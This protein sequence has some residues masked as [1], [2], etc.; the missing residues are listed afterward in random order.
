MAYEQPGW[1]WTP[2]SVVA[3]IFLDIYVNETWNK[4]FLASQGFQVA[5]VVFKRPAGVQAAKSSSLQEPLIISSDSHPVQT[6]IHSKLS[7]NATHFPFPYRSL[8]L[9][10]HSV[11]PK[12]YWTEL[13]IKDLI[14]SS[15]IWFQASDFLFIFLPDLTYDKIFR[16]KIKKGV[17]I[18]K[19]WVLSNKKWNA[20]IIKSI[21]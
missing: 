20:N 18:P 12:K 21:C 13:E 17:E 11:V 14:L 16:M 6:G 1:G 4:L 5:Y 9:G 15:H 19:G 2:I 7:T 10:L 3:L 8:N